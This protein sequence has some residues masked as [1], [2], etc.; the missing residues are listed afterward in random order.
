MSAAPPRRAPRADRA[1]DPEHTP[2]EA[3]FPALHSETSKAMARD[4][5]RGLQT[6]SKPLSP[7]NL[8]LLYD[9]NRRDMEL[10]YYIVALHKRRVRLCLRTS[11]SYRGPREHENAELD[12][13]HK[14]VESLVRVKD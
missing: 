13:V 14:S 11:G 5:A 3:D 6:K 12:W 7:H 1:G 10:Y 8:D 2:D 4:I 9:L